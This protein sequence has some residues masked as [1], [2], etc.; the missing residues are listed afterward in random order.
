M[1]EINKLKFVM[2]MSVT[3]GLTSRKFSRNESSTS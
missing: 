1:P 2:I 3:K